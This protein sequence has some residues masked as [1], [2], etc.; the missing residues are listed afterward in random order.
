MK[1]RTRGCARKKEGG[2]EK[3][4]ILEQ[5]SGSKTQGNTGREGEDGGKEG[6][7]SLAVNHRPG[8]NVVVTGFIVPVHYLRRVI[9]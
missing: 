3:V 6:G 5:C 4:E 8:R 7:G 1:K 9:L 2:K